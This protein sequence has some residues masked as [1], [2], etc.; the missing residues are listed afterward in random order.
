MY[1]S[2]K[3]DSLSALAVIAE[4]WVAKPPAVLDLPTDYTINKVVMLGNLS[5]AGIPTGAVNVLDQL[6]V[7]QVGVFCNFADGLIF[8]P[9]TDMYAQIGYT[10]D[11]ATFLGDKLWVR[12]PT[13][14]TM[15]ECNRFLP[16]KALVAAGD[17]LRVLATMS[18]A[19][20]ATGKFATGA[21]NPDLADDG[22]GP[23]GASGLRFDVVMTV[24]HS[25]E[26]TA[27]P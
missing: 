19:G 6:W 16:G 26:F 4:D 17:T 15:Y 7:A 5:G 10:V 27:T 21:V 13:L 23:V 11:G 12:I 3:E 9:D 14:N 2:Y 22:T 1:P 25:Y 20:A 18:G 8:M 24:K